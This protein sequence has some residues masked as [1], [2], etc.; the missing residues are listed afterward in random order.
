VRRSRTAASG[1]PLDD[2]KPEPIRRRRWPRG[3]TD[4]LRLT[5]GARSRSSGP[6]TART[7]SRIGQS[8]HSF[9]T[10]KRPDV[11][12]YVETGL[13]MSV[14][15][16]APAPP[17][18]TIPRPP[19]TKKTPSRPRRPCGKSG[20]HAALSAR[21]RVRSGVRD[22]QRYATLDLDQAAIGCC[23]ATVRFACRSLLAM[24]PSG[25]W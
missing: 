21:V 13:L 23:S 12:N 17:R 20:H 6:R 7:S 5:G 19:S 9:E 3:R 10:N 24:P 16:V 4:G 1:R 22:I 25:W 14:I 18:K 8:R 2:A 15:A 11:R